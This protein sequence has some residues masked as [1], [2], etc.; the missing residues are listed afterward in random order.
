M[1][2]E[3]NF[4]SHSGIK[5][6]TWKLRRF[7]NPDGSLTPE[8]RER[9]RKMRQAR[10]GKTEEKPEAPKPKKVTEMTDDELREKINRINL[11]KSYY[12]AEKNRLS[13]MAEVKKYAPDTRTTGQKFFASIRD[14]VVLPAAKEAGK[15]MLKSYMKAYGIK[16]VNEALGMTDDK[17]KDNKDKK[18]DKK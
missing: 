10:E 17:K 3:S 2:W 18:D 6:Q 1:N 14:E 15:E 12:E 9:Y 16:T 4:V 7:Q 5:G 8:G 13:N 11:E